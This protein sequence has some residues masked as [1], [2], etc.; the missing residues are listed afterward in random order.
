MRLCRFHHAQL[1][2]HRTKAS[3][4]RPRRGANG[5]VLFWHGEELL[6]VSEPQR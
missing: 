1:D 4:V 6:G 2:Q 3:P 5:A